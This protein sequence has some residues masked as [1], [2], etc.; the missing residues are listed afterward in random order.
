MDGRELYREIHKRKIELPVIIFFDAIS[1]D[2]VQSIHQIGRPAIVEKGSH[3]SEMPI[4][5]D[6]IKKMVYFG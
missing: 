4:F 6:L 2:E 1:D 5:I 3:Q